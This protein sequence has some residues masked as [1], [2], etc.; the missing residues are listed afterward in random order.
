MQNLPRE[1]D[2]LVVG[3]GPAGLA[4]ALAV[5]RKGL[6]AVVVDSAAPPIDKAC[7]EGLMPDSVAALSALGVK[8]DPARSFAFKGIRFLS[9]AACAEAVFPHGNGVGIRRVALHETLIEH[10]LEAGVDFAWQ[11]RLTGAR[12]YCAYIN[13]Q[14]ISFRWIVGADGGN[15]TMRRWASLDTMQQLAP[16]YGF[17]RHYRI[18]P[19]TDFM[20][21]HW[22]TDCQIYVTPVRDDEV[23][24]ALISRNPQ[25]RI[26]D[27]LPL[28]PDISRRLAGAPHASAERGAV[29]ASR[30]LHRVQSGRLALVGDASGSVDA[31]TGEG[32]CL[33]F[34]QALA[35]AN[36]MVKDD[37][38]AY[39]SAHRRIRFRPAMMSSMLLRMDRH[40][41]LQERALAALSKHPGMFARML[42][43]HVGAASKRDIATNIFKLGWSILTL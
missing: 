43:T 3:G 8:L 5:R 1:T 31:I 16:R 42:A 41:W 34:K 38:P 33:A 10:A 28:F 4:T 40:P 27:A 36:A 19:W 17:R 20:E 37:L 11:Q 39:E 6:R 24:I 35:L 26:D 30:R 32:I 22:G 14:L 23:G 29:S 7:G 25:L 9:P 15:S 12:D 2:V 21:L 13:G 18:R